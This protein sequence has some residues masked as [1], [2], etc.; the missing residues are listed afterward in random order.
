MYVE[1]RK[2]SLLVYPTI[3]TYTSF[4]TYGRRLLEGKEAYSARIERASMMKG[5]KRVE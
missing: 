1:H 4:Q 5:S 2:S 3:H